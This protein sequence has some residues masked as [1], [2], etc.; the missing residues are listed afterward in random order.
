MCRVS[1]DGVWYRK[2]SY[3][4]KTDKCVGVRISRDR[5][6]VTNTRTIGPVVEF[7]T[8]E[9]QA[10]LSGVEAHEFDLREE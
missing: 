7:S 8:A 3:S 9:W 2:S 1:V 4:Y 10:F 6:F 5:V